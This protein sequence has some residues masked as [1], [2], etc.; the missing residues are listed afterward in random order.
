MLEHTQGR[1]I[2]AEAA[3]EKTNLHVPCETGWVLLPKTGV[4]T[5]MYV[6]KYL[7]ITF[8]QQNSNLKNMLHLLFEISSP[9]L[10]GTF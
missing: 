7:L 5:S 3:R 9:R 2:I 4:F 1:K 10:K 8:T 6:W